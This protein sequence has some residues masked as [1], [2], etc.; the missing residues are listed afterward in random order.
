MAV[1]DI[2]DNDVVIIPGSIKAVIFKGEEQLLGDAYT[3]PIGGTTASL[4]FDDLLN[5]NEYTIKILANYNLQDGSMTTIE[6][7]LIAS[8]VINTSPLSVPQ[9]QLINM[10]ILEACIP[11]TAIEIINLKHTEKT[12]ETGEREDHYSSGVIRC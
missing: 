5:V 10:N 2:T 11:F 1:V 7:Y 6:D 8:Y 12:I 4:N 9:P 3:K